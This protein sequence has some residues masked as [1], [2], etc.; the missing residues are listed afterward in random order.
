MNV[1]KRLTLA[2]AATLLA[3]LAADSGPALSA[4]TPLPPNRLAAPQLTAQVRADRPEQARDLAFWN[5]IRHSADPA[6]YHAYLRA[7]P[8]GA[9]AAEA[10]AKSASDLVMTPTADEPAPT[11]GLRAST[12]RRQLP[13]VFSD[14]A[15]TA[16]DPAAAAELYRLAA[17]TGDIR[18]A[19]DLAA[20]Y[21]KGEGVPRSLDEARHWYRFAAERGDA[22]AMQNLGRLYEADRDIEMARQL[23]EAAANQ[24]SE[25]ARTALRRLTKPA[26]PP[27]TPAPAVQ[28]TPPPKCM[29]ILVNAQL[30]HLSQQD[31]EFLQK[32]CA[33]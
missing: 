10:R 9:F 31:Q 22:L 16:E 2:C 21:E 3:H 18:A 5:S 26:A 20:L 33:Q 4:G 17:E 8:D 12:S 25:F 30:G 14:I 7:F 29:D 13:M 24:G 15:R 1:Y 28:K 32:E 11:S 27:A 6:D 23:Y 19:V